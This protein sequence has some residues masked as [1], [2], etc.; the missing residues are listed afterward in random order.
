M[1][2]S[3]VQHNVR[4][5][6]SIDGQPANLKSKRVQGSSSFT[7]VAVEQGQYIKGTYSFN[8]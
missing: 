6:L 1:Y 7:R 2:A 4:A 5:R 8:S 3:R